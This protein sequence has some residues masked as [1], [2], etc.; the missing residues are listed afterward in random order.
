[1]NKKALIIGNGIISTHITPY[2]DVVDYILALD[3]N[4]H[5]LSH[6][7]PI[8]EV[9]A[10]L[11]DFDTISNMA[12]IQEKYPHI[13]IIPAPDQNYTD[14]EKGL[15]YLIDQGY[16]TIYGFGLTG[17]RMDHTFNNIVALAKYTDTITI[18]LIDDYSKIECIPNRF[19][20]MYQ[21]NTIISLF[22]IGEVTGIYTTNLKYPLHDATLTLMGPTGSSNKVAIDGLVSI[23]YQSGKLIL[24]ECWD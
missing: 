21:Q 19:S 9:N 3:Y 24:M 8:H 5:T 6:I 12:I 20:R 13:K 1:M 2:L 18:Q 16:E 10:I 23:H 7:L 14:F 22:P 15:Q 11:G 17:N 4:V